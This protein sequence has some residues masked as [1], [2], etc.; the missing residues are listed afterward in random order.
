M[1]D[2]RRFLETLAQR[3]GAIALEH[4]RAPR[5]L[6]IRAKGTLDFVTKADIAVET[7]IVAEI[8]LRFPD[9]GILGEEGQAR[10]GTSGR[11]WI[12]DPIDGTHNFMRGLPLWGI[13]IGVIANGKPLAGVIH[14]PAMALTVSAQAGQGAWLN[15]APLSRD[16]DESAANLALVG[17]ASKLPL[18]YSHWLSA[19]VREDLRLDER[20]FGAATS[21][22]LAVALRQADIYLT[23]GDHIWD[24]AAGSAILGEVGLA[25]SFDWSAPLHRGMNMFVCGRAP[26]VTRTIAAMRRDWPKGLNAS[27]AVAE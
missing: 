22:I 21:A 20:R 26:L 15:Q 12:I 6:D 17:L 19:F 3:V 18:A 8:S 14:A 5:N 4:Q 10:E 27:P 23:F 24:F 13:S 7:A 2:F 9:D 16:D 1:D 25:H 11:I